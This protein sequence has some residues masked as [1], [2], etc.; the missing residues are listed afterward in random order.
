MRDRYAEFKQLGSA[1]VVVS[2][3]PPAL[4][5]AYLEK[6]PMPFAVVSDSSRTA[7]QAFGLVRTS[8]GSIFRASVVGRYLG[9]ILRGWLPR[10]PQSEEDVMQ[11]GDDFVL[12]G[13]RR[14]VYAYRSTEPTDRPT[15]DDLLTAVRRASRS[16]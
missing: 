15:V 10:R 2:F 13:Q 1:V 3:A 16:R 11:L 9:L 8:W 5:T 4:V 7:Y 12:D 14:L 6:S